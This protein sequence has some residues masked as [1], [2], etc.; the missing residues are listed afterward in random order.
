MM[1]RAPRAVDLLAKSADPPRYPPK[2]RRKGPASWGEV[3][4]AGTT[5]CEQTAKI[6]FANSVG[7]F[8]K[9]FPSIRISQ[10]ADVENWPQ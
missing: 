8:C 2:H 5:Y 4:F 3:G 10:K 6:D 1:V 7:S 9:E